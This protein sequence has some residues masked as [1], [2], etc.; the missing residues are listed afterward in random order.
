VSS[1]PVEADYLEVR[2][3]FPV[4]A[5]YLEVKPVFS[6]LVEVLRLNVK[7]MFSFPVE[8]LYLEVKP[9]FSF[10]V[11]VLRLNVKLVFSFP[12]EVLHLEVKL[13][14]GRWMGDGS[15]CSVFLRVG[16]REDRSK[17]AI[18]RSLHFGLVLVGFAS[19]MLIQL[20]LS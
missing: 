13:W 8:A 10:P 3:S 2:F 18:S 12:V 20:P 19:V 16:N 14:Q 6:F 15:S 17:T 9:V 4:E 11:E 5:L 7:L 1:F